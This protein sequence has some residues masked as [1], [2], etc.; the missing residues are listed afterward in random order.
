MVV[1]EMAMSN[2]VLVA[3][4]AQMMVVEMATKIKEIVV[5]VV[6]IEEMRQMFEFRVAK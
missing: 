4:A 6:K 1:V 3:A 5:V 2:E